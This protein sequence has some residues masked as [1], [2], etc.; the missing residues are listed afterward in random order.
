M[1]TP[2][3]GIFCSA[4][5]KSVE[6]W[7]T[8]LS[9]SVKLPG[10]HS[11]ASALARGQLARLVLALHAFGA[12]GGVGLPVQLGQTFGRGGRGSHGTSPGGSGGR[13]SRSA[14]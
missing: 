10:S 14:R 12:A 9:I 1:T 7:V 8:K 11:S 5:P 4:M 13:P 6:R 2:S 3:P